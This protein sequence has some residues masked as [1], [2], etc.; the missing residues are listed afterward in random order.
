MQKFDYGIIL[1]EKLRGERGFLDA[2]NVAREGG[3]SPTFMGKVAQ[4]LKRIGWLKSRRGQG[5]GYKLADDF[6]KISVAE[7]LTFFQKPY[8]VCPINRIIKK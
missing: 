1:V 6:K 8:K 3:L 5:G 2:K 4:E 7:V